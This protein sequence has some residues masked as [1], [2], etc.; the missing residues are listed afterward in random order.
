MSRMVWR[1]PWVLA[2]WYEEKQ[3][4]R[5]PLFKKYTEQLEVPFCVFKA[6]LQVLSSSPPM[7]GA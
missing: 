1:W 5:V 3:E 2:G 6:Y 7:G 4:L